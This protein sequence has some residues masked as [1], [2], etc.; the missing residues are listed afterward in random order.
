[1]RRKHKYARLPSFKLQFTAGFE[2]DGREEKKKRRNVNEKQKKKN[3][4]FTRVCFG[5][6]K[7]KKKGHTTVR[8]LLEKIK[9]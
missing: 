4:L 2:A 3:I 8:I 5:I 6:Q 9:F 1:M 7:K